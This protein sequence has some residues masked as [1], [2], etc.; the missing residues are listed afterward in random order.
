MQLTTSIGSFT[1]C[2]SSVLLTVLHCGSL[3][4][5]GVNLRNLVGQTCSHFFWTAKGKFSEL[6]GFWLIKYGIGQLLRSGT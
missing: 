6:L 1:S 3:F 2:C 4:P 5:Q